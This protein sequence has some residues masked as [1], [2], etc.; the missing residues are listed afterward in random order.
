[1]QGSVCDRVLVALHGVYCLAVIC[2]GFLCSLCPVRD[3][4]EYGRIDLSTTCITFLVITLWVS[5]YAIKV[6]LLF[7]ILN[8]C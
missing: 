5:K 7:Q 3:L 8:T 1:M 2:Y 4:V 6:V